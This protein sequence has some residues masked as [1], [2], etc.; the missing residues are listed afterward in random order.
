LERS[1]RLFFFLGRACW[2]AQVPAKLSHISIVIVI[3]ESVVKRM[4][5]RLLNV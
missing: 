2:T 3:E 4:D 5:L 1:L